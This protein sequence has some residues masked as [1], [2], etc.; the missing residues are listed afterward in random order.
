MRVQA[1]GRGGWAG[2][3]IQERERWQKSVGDEVSEGKN[4]TRAG[5]WM[6]FQGR[7]DSG[8]EE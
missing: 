3:E 6:G 1:G 5:G 4:T 2:L 7:G 8:G